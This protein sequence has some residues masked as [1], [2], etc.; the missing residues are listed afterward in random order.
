MKTRLFVA[1]VAQRC[2][3]SE[4]INHMLYETMFIMIVVPKEAFVD[5]NETLCMVFDSNQ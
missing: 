5:S 3:I 2:L 1:K 4:M